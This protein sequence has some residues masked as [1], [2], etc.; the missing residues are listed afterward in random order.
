MNKKQLIRSYIG[1]VTEDSIPFNVLNSNNMRNILKPICD[2][3][4]AT[5][6]KSFCLNA[7][8]C[9]KTL[10]IVANNLRKDMK[11][12]LKNKLLSLKIDSASRLCRNIFGIS[13]QFI[14]ELEIKSRILEMV[15]LKGVGCSTSKSLAMEI[16]KILSKY[17]VNL[18]QIV[19]VTSD[20]GANML[21]ATKI[22]S[23]VSEEEIGENEVDSND[24]YL[25]KSIS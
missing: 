13:A 1:L 23:V 10:E 16:I 21:K 15:E 20:N 14:S 6:G 9:K 22:L 25:K 2:G 5:D 3:F 12:E 4:K 18:K 17:E 11:D 24:E 19:S 8:N 7:S